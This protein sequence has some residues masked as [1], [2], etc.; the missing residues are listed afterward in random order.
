MKTSQFEAVK[1]A[2]KQDKDGYVLTLRMHPDEVPEDI[3]RDFVGAR[4]Q[5]VMVRLNGAEQPMNR[6]TEYERDLVRSAGILCR[7][8]EFA[9]YLMELDHVIDPS[10]SFIVDWL[11]E[12]LQIK[13]R[14][15]L[16]TNPAAAKAFV[17]LQ[18][19]FNEWKLLRD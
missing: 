5:V 8:K 16:K 1:I 6:E 11:R 19:D 2:I 18:Q 12:H 4:Y 3:L 10:E 17:Q 13:S 15:E 9:E 14:S 7:D